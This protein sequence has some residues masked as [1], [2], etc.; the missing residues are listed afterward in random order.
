MVAQR[1]SVEAYCNEARRRGA[2][3]RGDFAEPGVHGRL[4]AAAVPVWLLGIWAMP[5]LP[6]L[7]A[8]AGNDPQGARRVSVGHSAARQRRFGIAA[9]DRLRAGVEDISGR[10]LQGVCLSLRAVLDVQGVRDGQ[11]Q[12]RARSPPA[13]IP[14]WPG[15]RWRRRGSTFS[16]PPAPPDCRS[17]WSAR[18]SVRRITMRWC[19]WSNGAMSSHFFLRDSA[20]GPDRPLPPDEHVAGGR[21]RRPHRLARE[22][23]RAAGPLRRHLLDDQPRRQPRRVAQRRPGRHRRL[24]P[25]HLP[26]NGPG[27]RTDRASRRHLRRIG[28][29]VSGPPHH[30]ADFSGGH[31][32]AHAATGGLAWASSVS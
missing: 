16:P 21:H 13:G 5:D 23:E 3:C 4:G 10:L 24:L 2:G 30:A 20:Q 31:H 12:A 17:K 6:A 15:P 18:R 14:T 19:W 28:R 26:R 8:H 9:K 1:E 11:I 29:P 27:G 25:R 7:F 32:L 22:A